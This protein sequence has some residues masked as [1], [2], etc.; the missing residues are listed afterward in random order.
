MPKFLDNIEFYTEGRSEERLTIEKDE[1]YV[2]LKADW[3]TE[4]IDL[5]I[6]ETIITYQAEGPTKKKITDISRDIEKEKD[7]AV[8]KIGTLSEVGLKETNDLVQKGLK[9]LDS[10]TETGLGQLQDKIDEFNLENGTGDVLVQTKDSNHSF[11]IM[12]D[13]RVKV[14]GEPIENDDALRLN[15]FSVLTQEKVDSLF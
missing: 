2:A 13:G 4:T 12:I 11:K 6:P 14:Y 3:N 10:K 15:E 1:K 8:Y 7:E 9:A 5:S